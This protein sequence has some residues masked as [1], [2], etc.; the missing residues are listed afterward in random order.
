MMYPVSVPMFGK[1]PRFIVRLK[2]CRELEMV[3]V[4]PSGPGC[5]GSL[6]SMEAQMPAHTGLG[7]LLY[8]LRRRRR[9]IRRRRSAVVAK[10]EAGAQT[11]P[12]AKLMWLD[13]CANAFK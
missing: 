12:A 4:A 5:H 7:R 3:A 1:E 11:S 2:G 9:K 6:P 8:A 13:V 10:R